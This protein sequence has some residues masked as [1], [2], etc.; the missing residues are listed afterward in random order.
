M[1]CPETPPTAER[2][3]E[4]SEWCFDTACFDP[5]K[6]NLHHAEHG[7]A[8]LQG[9]D[10]NPVARSIDIN[11]L[12]C[13]RSF[14]QFPWTFLYDNPNTDRGD[15]FQAYLWVRFDKHSRFISELEKI[16]PDRVQELRRN[17]E[18]LSKD[19]EDFVKYGPKRRLLASL[20][21]WSEKWKSSRRDAVGRHGGM[22]GRLVRSATSWPRRNPPK[23]NKREECQPSV[24]DEPAAET[25]AC[26]PPTSAQR[27]AEA[28]SIPRDEQGFGNHYNVGVMRFERK[29]GSTSF[30]GAAFDL[31]S[32]PGG[33]TQLFPNQRVPVDDILSKDEAKIKVNP[34]AA[35][36]GK[37]ELRYIHFPA[38]NM[39]WIEVRDAGSGEVW[40]C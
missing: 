14:T 34:L 19:R 22:P 16:N 15:D 5:E 31:P 12:H 24:A 13:R 3:P 11:C 29:P 38:N 37:D 6:L 18:K 23:S 17:L 32:A 4:H 25:K 30:A 1:N 28:N 10:P 8:A 39:S 27:A 40:L 20:G 9:T 7:R 2:S 21:G 26:N 35:K 36:C 33:K